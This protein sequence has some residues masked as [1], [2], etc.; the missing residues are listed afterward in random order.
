MGEDE[1]GYFLFTLI[2]IL[3]LL[4]NYGRGDCLSYVGTEGTFLH[5]SILPH[6]AEN[7]IQVPNGLLVTDS[8]LVPLASE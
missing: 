7:A 1:E 4:S 8:V 3:A 2:P 6:S 5:S